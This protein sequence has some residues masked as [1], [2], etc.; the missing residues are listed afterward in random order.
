MTNADAGASNTLDLKMNNQIWVKSLRMRFKV[1]KMTKRRKDRKCR[2]M[3]K[4]WNVNAVKITE[5]EFSETG[6]K[7]KNR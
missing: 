6:K 7:E 1:K 3:G 2:G 5:N 4:W